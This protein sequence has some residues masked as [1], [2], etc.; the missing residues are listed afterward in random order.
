MQVLSCNNR[1]VNSLQNFL[2]NSTTVF[3]I[4]GQNWIKFVE[5]FSLNCF[6]F[7]RN[8]GKVDFT[9]RKSSCELGK[10][11]NCGVINF[12]TFF[13]KTSPRAVKFFNCLIKRR[14][15]DFIA[16]FFAYYGIKVL[17]FSRNFNLGY[18][19]CVTTKIVT[20]V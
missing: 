3:N 19:I 17:A 1:V 12:V 9:T 7:A 4:C 6:K 16:L 11:N 15:N 18:N 10:F 14:W 13:I 8:N 20:C 2:C 5:S